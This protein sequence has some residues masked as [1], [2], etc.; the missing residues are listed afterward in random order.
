MT[1]GK[2][3]EGGVGRSFFRDSQRERIAHNHAAVVGA[4]LQIFGE[5]QYA[6]LNLCCRDDQT[7]P[8]VQ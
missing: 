5:Q 3:W 1:G 8:P 2:L 7:I 6:T 4:I